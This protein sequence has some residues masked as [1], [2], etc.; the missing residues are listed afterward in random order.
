M[1]IYSQVQSLALLGNKAKQ[2]YISKD[3]KFKS[4]LMWRER[5]IVTCAFQSV[6]SI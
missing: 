2:V 6:I 3:H 1:L 5:N 4:S